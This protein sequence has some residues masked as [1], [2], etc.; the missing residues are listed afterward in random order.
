MVQCAVSL[1]TLYRSRV[2]CCKC[3]IVIGQSML[4][5]GKGALLLLLLC[6]GIHMRLI[7]VCPLL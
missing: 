6:N 7:G 2:G 1:G 3:P 4:L 5:G